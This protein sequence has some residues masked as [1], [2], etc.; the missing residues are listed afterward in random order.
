MSKNE[1]SNHILL[2]WETE[3]RVV[4]VNRDDKWNVKSMTVKCHVFVCC[5]FQSM[6]QDW[7]K[8]PQHKAQH[9]SYLLNNFI[10]YF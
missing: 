2:W 1:A 4:W 9:E 7:F 5:L 3:E 8:L 10:Y 6:K